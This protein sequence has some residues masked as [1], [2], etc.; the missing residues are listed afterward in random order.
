VEGIFFLLIGGALFA[1]SWYILGLYSEGRTMGIFVGGLGL[2]SLGT[3]IWIEP[4]LLTAI[5]EKG[6]EVAARDVLMHKTVISTVIVAWSLYA[7]GVAS[8]GLWDL[9]ERAIGFY[10]IF[11][12]VATLG[13]FVY[14]AVALGPPDLVYAES[15]W[16]GM[17]IA[18]LVLSIVAAIM[19]FYLAI[20]SNVLRLVAG[21]FTL[22]GGTVVALIGLAAVTTL[23][24]VP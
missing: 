23:I 5:G 20:A 10:S 15:V 12:A 13:P 19:F 21:W 22:I 14:F 3:L 8:H 4:T 24:T 11:L 17:W 2:L 7:V 9:D 1:Q 16:I 18:T 6:K